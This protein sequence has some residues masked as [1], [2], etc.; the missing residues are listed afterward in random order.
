MTSGKTRVDLLHSSADQ[1]GSLTEQWKHDPEEQHVTSR[2]IKHVPLVILMLL[3]QIKYHMHIA[4]GNTKLKH[5]RMQK[6]MHF[7]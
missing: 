6:K 5:Q 7:S 4:V 2:Q 1:T 3:E